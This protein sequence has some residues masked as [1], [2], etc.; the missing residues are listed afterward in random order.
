MRR[1]IAIFG[2]CTIFLCN[3]E[4]S[5]MKS[6]DIFAMDT[7]MNLKAYGENGDS[8]LNSAENEIHRLEQ[9]FS[10]TDE[11]SEIFKINNSNGEK[12]SV[13]DDT[14]QIIAFSKEMGTATNGCLDISVY[15]LVKE[16]GFTTGNYK[17]PEKL[18]ITQLLSDVD[19]TKIDITGNTVAI[20]EKMEIDLGAVAKGYTADKIVEIYKENG[21]E[22][23]IINLG[24]NVYA[25]GK[26][27]DGTRW[28]VAIV[29]PLS[30]AETLGK[31]EVSDKAVVTSGNYQRYFTG[32][33]GK[34]YCHIIDTST[35][36]PADNGLISV[37]IISD[38]GA[39][40]DA[41]S[42]ALFVM[43]KENAQTYLQNNPDISAILVEENGDILIS[44][45][46]SEDFQCF[47]DNAVEVLYDQN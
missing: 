5:E 38:T 18:R 15:P 29:N 1:F 3:C 20:P 10:V 31:L 6:R 19:Y 35:G 21:V 34:N 36:F 47:T 2:I 37:T 32:E 39:I 28:N 13:S 23:G 40:S 7:Y 11:N 45:A 12:I 43:G 33:D 25:M 26:K 14:S 27:P 4:N 30:P 22:S 41:L 16:W 44:E 9:L 42:T 8:A 46:I 17:I 24:G